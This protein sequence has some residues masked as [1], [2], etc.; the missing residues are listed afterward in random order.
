[1]R[2][3]C[4]YSSYFTQDY[5][6]YY[7]KF[8]LE[9]LEKHFSEIIFLTNEKQ[10]KET[11]LDYLK[12]RNIVLKFVSNEGFDFGMWHKAFKEYPSLSYDRV[13]LVNDSCILFKP[14]TDIFRWIDSNDF[15]Y[16]GLVSSKSVA[17]HVQSYFIVINKNAIKP[18]YDYF[19]ENGLISDYKK[20]IY[21]YEIGLSATLRKQGLKVAAMFTSKNDIAAQNPSFLVIEEFIRGGLPMIKKKIIF[22]SYRKGE[23]L[24]MLRMNFKLN[25][26]VYIKLIKEINKNVLLIDF[27]LAIKD[28]KRSSNIDIY[29][30]NMVL[31]FYQTAK[32][33]KSLT[34]LFHKLI[35]IRRK[36]RGDTSTNILAG[37]DDDE[38]V[39]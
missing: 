14:L 29:L 24:S 1:M 16:C 17:L 34:A 36:L 10:L 32:R 22:R 7:V 39:N 13:A 9:E 12:Q 11:E 37:T 35:L 27:D 23:Y 19:M 15:D 26:N 8:Y 4:F 21:T 2:S 25:Q 20:V 31:F 30:Y 18:V 3:I 5:I 38:T 28:F 6:P 33:S